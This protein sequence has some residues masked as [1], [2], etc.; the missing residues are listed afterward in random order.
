[1]HREVM[2]RTW[3]C[4]NSQAWISY[5]CNKSPYLEGAGLIPTAIYNSVV[6]RLV[7]LYSPDRA[8]VVAGSLTAVHSTP[9]HPQPDTA[10]TR[11]LCRSRIREPFQVE[12]TVFIQQR[13]FL[14][15][16]RHGVM[17]QLYLSG[18][19]NL[20]RFVRPSPLLCIALHSSRTCGEK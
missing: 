6:G 19:C 17:L 1:M 9:A 12:I 13:G 10:P 14:I 20:V 3:R 5:E 4:I 8:H 7:F 18:I 15:E 2:L 11:L 16:M